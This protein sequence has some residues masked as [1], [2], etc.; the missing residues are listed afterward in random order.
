MSKLRGKYLYEEMS[1]KE[2]EACFRVK[3]KI[4]YLIGS[5]CFALYCF[6]ITDYRYG[7]SSGVSKRIVL[8]RKTLEKICSNYNGQLFERKRIWVSPDSWYLSNKLVECDQLEKEEMNFLNE[9]DSDTYLDICLIQYLFGLNSS[10]LEVAKRQWHKYKLGRVRT[11][12]VD[13]SVK[14]LS[15]WHKRGRKKGANSLNGD[16]LERVEYNLSCY[17]KIVQSCVEKD[18]YEVFCDLKK[19]LAKYKKE[20]FNRS[21]AKWEFEYLRYKWKVDA[22][23][24]SRDL[25]VEKEL[26]RKGQKYNFI[27]IF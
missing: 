2:K 1:E 23:F 21:A 13:L 18:R 4:R 8:S 16:E 14:D 26:L 3:P 17:D 27:C 19:D 11:V 6:S 15:S 5:D 9:V 12:F 10:V 22:G 7:I 20:K 24:R 25:E